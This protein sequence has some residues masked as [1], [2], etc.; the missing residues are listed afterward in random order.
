MC[1][2]CV[3]V[4]VC[5]QYFRRNLEGDTHAVSTGSTVNAGGSFASL[6]AAT[7]GGGGGDGGGGVGEEGSRSGSNVIDLG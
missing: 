2:L 3:C 1:V 6:P 5:T 4:C 7:G